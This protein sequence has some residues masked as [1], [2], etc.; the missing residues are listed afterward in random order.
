MN[1]AIK[2][3]LR[4]L[5]PTVVR[6]LQDKYPE[7]VVRI[8]VE[9]PAEG[10]DEQ[11]FWGLIALLDWGRK[12]NEDII[13]PVVKALSKLPEAGIFRFEDI[14]AQRLFALD[15]EKY[16]TPLGWNS[17]TTTSFSVDVFLYAR[18]CVVANGRRFY[19]KVLNNPAL[20]PKDCTFESLLYIARKA[21]WLKTGGDTYDYL[22][23]TSYETFSNHTGWPEMPSLQDLIKGSGQ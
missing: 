9:G 19:E 11:H 15:G 6:D 22:P 10:M 1:T 17:E 12:R 4:S 18:C 14:L 2:L 23:E 16:A 13:A 8:E 20:M 3:P 7:A 5:T 21:H